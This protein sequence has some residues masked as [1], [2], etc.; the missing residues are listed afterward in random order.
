[1]FARRRKKICRTVFK[2]LEKMR[3]V[4]AKNFPFLS[5]KPHA[6]K[7]P[8]PKKGY[9]KIAKFFD[10]FIKYDYILNILPE[11]LS[12]MNIDIRHLIIRLCERIE[13]CTTLWLFIFFYLVGDLWIGKLQ[14]AEP[15]K[16]IVG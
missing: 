12:Y 5:S 9:K 8:R 16:N 13:W 6:L 1:M 2:S 4:C 7:N 15:N 11:F 3:N 14:I 10:R